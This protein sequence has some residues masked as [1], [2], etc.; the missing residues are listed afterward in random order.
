MLT[1]LYSPANGFA[2]AL[3][4]RTRGGGVRSRACARAHRR[5]LFALAE[6][7]GVSSGVM[8]VAWRGKNSMLAGW[9][10]WLTWLTDSLAWPHLAHL[11]SLPSWLLAH[12]S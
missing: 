10:A 2:A 12:H 3:L 8:T 9:L 5:A 6:W 11:A 4:A 1:L 7:R